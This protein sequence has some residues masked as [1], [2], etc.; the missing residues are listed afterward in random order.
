MAITLNQMQEDIHSQILR[1]YD[2]RSAYH[3]Q[4][5][6]FMGLA[7]ETGEVLG[8]AKRKIRGFKSD[9]KDVTIGHFVEELGD[10]LWYLIAL[11]DVHGISIDMVWELNKQ[12]LEE[13]YG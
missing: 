9:E 11:C 3:L 4:N 8:I 12:K 7:E 10:V 13:R 5:M 1:D 6:M 2:G